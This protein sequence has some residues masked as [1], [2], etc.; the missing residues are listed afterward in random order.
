MS[1]KSIVFVSYSDYI[2]GADNAFRRIFEA[3]C[4]SDRFNDLEL[5]LV[6]SN[7]RNARRPIKSKTVS[8]RRTS[9]RRLAKKI[10][11]GTYR[12]LG[13]TGVFSSASIS[14][15][16]AR[17]VGGLN[18]DV[19]VLNWLGD[20]TDSLEEWASLKKKIIIRQA[21]YWWHSGSSH[22]PRTYTAK[23]GSVFGQFLDRFFFGS[24]DRKTLLRKQ[25]ILPELV[26]AVI[27]PAEFLSDRGRHSGLFPNA[28]FHHVPNLIDSTF[29]PNLERATA[30]R[31]LGISQNG[32]VIGFGAHN[33]FKDHRKGWALIARAI[34]GLEWHELGAIRE[35]PEIHVFG[36]ARQQFRIGQTNVYCHGF[37]DA[38]Q[39][40]TFYRSIDVFLSASFYE[41]SP[42]TVNECLAAGTP[43]SAFDLDSLSELSGRGQP[44]L[45]LVKP[46][47]ALQLLT[48]GLRIGGAYSANTKLQEEIAEH[49]RALHSPERSEASLRCAI[50]SVLALNAV[51]IAE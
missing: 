17:E 1:P 12:L 6:V 38:P 19:V 42:N 49:I 30:R 26:G 33:V 46:G 50:D 9:L 31:I 45:S 11:K 2:G 15:G 5:K 32:F 18:P 22:F 28:S 35:I 44:G 41:G 25:E 13:G 3:A 21:D 43:V 40:N 34:R 7:S 27:S 39:L 10:W 24:E 48:E 37:L 23:R 51:N 36:S 8:S 20:F 29:S 14:T 47:D 4:G 16:L